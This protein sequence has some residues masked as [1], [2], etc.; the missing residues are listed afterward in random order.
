M[1][2]DYYAQEIEDSEED[3]I[4]ALALNKY[5]SGQWTENVMAGGV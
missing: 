5:S 2:V 3:I 4:R 1:G